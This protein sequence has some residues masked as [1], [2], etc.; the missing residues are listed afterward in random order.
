MIPSNVDMASFEL[1]LWELR[2]TRGP[3]GDVGC[4]GSSGISGC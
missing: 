3:S 2:A 1:H 4:Q